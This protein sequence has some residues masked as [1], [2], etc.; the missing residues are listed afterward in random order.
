MWAGTGGDG[1]LADL[2]DFKTN[3]DRREGRKISIASSKD[4][5]ITPRLCSSGGGVS[6]G[7]FAADEGYFGPSND[8]LLKVWW[9]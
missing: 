3:A 9:I 2:S 7:G 8:K 1:S 4:S 5:L 6:E